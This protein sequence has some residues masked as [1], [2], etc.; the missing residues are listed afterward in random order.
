MAGYPLGGV[1]VLSESYFFGRADRPAPGVNLFRPAMAGCGECAGRALW[2]RGERGKCQ[3]PRLP[4]TSH[5]VCGGG[6]GRKTAYAGEGDA[7]CTA[8]PAGV[9]HV[10]DLT[11]ARPPTGSPRYVP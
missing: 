10:V 6:S 9:A 11:E 4:G 5:G 1:D 7:R 8:P 2:C 3:G